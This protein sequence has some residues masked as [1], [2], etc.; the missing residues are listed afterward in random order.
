MGI[1][2]DLGGGQS[3][4]LL[5]M[6]IPGADCEWCGCPIN[7]YGPPVSKSDC[8]CLYTDL[9]EDV[10]PHLPTFALF[11]LVSCYW[12]FCIDRS[13][14]FCFNHVAYIKSCLCIFRSL[15]VQSGGACCWRTFLV[16]WKH[17]P[18]LSSMTRTPLARHKSTTSGQSQA[19][20]GSNRHSRSLEA[21][22][23]LP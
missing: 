17:I 23:N 11:C 5:S 6:P 22:C 19:S 9:K 4:K 18:F 15:P 13:P 16:A 20:L 21:T 12:I 3:W 8:R 14:C 2:T 7:A 10:P 1:C